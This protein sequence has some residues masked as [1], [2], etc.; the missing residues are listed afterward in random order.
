MVCKRALPTAGAGATLII[1]R[2]EPFELR[3]VR[4]VTRE[5]LIAYSHIRRL[6][7]I[8]EGV[9]RRYATGPGFHVDPVVLLISEIARESPIRQRAIE[10][11]GPSLEAQRLRVLAFALRHGWGIAWGRGGLRVG[12]VGIE[13]VHESGP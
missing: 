5:G 3:R 6:C 1:E 7:H 8:C 4:I 2:I 12:R 13:D 11:I 9:P 10:R